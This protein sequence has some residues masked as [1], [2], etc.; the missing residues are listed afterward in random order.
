MEKQKLLIVGALIFAVGLGAGYLVSRYAFNAQLSQSEAMM[1][2]ESCKEKSG[3][4]AGYCGSFDQ[5]TCEDVASAL[6]D[7]RA[8]TRPA[9][10]MTQRPISPK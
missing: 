5:Q 10:S 3:T 6:C 8:A 7:W 4:P 1:A 2:Q 9:P